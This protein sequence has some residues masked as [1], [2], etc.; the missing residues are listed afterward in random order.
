M[1]IYFIKKTPYSL[2]IIFGYIFITFICPA[3]KCDKNIL[4]W[5]NILHCKKHEI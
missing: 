5:C 3:N 4:Y 2:F 1:D